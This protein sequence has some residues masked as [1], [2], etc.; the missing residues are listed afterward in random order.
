MQAT[1]ALGTPTF[2][3][4]NLPTGLSISSSG[5]ITGTIAAGA[6]AKGPYK[7]TITATDG[8]CKVASQTFCGPWPRR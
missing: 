2:T 1:D 6:A 5:K 7:V 4:T 3:A 8:S